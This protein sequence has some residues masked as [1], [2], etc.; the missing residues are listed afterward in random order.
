MVHLVVALGVHDAV[1]VRE[2]VGDA[3]L[4][5]LPAELGQLREALTAGLDGLQPVLVHA[6]EV[7]RGE[8]LNG[9]LLRDGQQLLLVHR[10]TGAAEPAVAGTGA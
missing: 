10:R 9:V 5:E 3:L 8:Q 2:L 1:V 4:G 6:H 7:V